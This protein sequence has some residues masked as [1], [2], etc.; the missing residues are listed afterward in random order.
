MHSLALNQ[1]TLLNENLYNRKYNKLDKT[2]NVL[3]SS[4]KALFSR[5][6]LSY[7][8]IGVQQEYMKRN[9]DCEVSYGKSR[10]LANKIGDKAILKRLSNSSN[11][12]TSS[13]YNLSHSNSNL[14]NKHNQ[15]GSNVG[16]S[17]NFTL[18]SPEINEIK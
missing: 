11:K 13:N 10:N 9:L 5:M 17:Q 4:K 18:Y 7:F 8:N 6:M 12:K 3:D 15:S 14:N 2:R 16:N 1:L